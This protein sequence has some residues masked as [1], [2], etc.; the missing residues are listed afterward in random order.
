MVHKWVLPPLPNLDK[1]GALMSFTCAVH[2]VL[3][4]LLI[5]IMPWLGASFLYDRKIEFFFIVG[6][7]FLATLSYSYGF[8]LHRKI[9]LMLMLYLCT[10]M[11]VGWK[12]SHRRRAGLVGGGP[13][14][15]R[16][17]DRAPVEHA[18]LPTLRGGGTSTSGL[19]MN[20]GEKGWG[21]LPSFSWFWLLRPGA[22]AWPP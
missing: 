17:G 4:P 22:K 21:G 1:A 13:R 11:I 18:A 16:L 15:P 6:S 20:Q 19:R 14:G 2:C 5:V 9:Y 7:V 3:F 12:G 10:G 8:H